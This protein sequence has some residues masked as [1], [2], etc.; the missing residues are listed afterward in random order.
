M[1]N[2]RERVCL[3]LSRDYQTNEYLVIVSIY[4]GGAFRRHEPAT[5]Y[6]DD[7]QDAIDTR[8]AMEKEY[9]TKGYQVTL[10]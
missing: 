6:T 4:K 7:R 10:K 9:L 3:R 1:P 5:Y 8:N 2:F